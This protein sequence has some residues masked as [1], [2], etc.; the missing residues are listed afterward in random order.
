M[1][2]LKDLMAKWHRDPFY[3]SAVVLGVDIGLEGIGVWLRKGVKPLF[4]ATYL[5]SLPEA[6]PLENR[7]LKRSARR[8]RKSRKHRDFLFRQ[9]CAKCDL[10]TTPLEKKNHDPFKLRH[11]AVTSQLKSKEG[12]VICLHHLVRHRGYDYHLTEE[13]AY[14]WGD[15]LRKQDIL[16]WARTTACRPDYAKDIQYLISDWPE[17]DRDS[18]LTALEEAV[19][20]YESQPILRALRTYVAEKKP[21]LRAPIRGTQNNYPRE[22]VTAHAREIL[23]RHKS[24]FQPGPSFSQAVEELLGDKTGII[25][26]HRKEPGALADRKIKPCPFAP[27][28]FAGKKEKC[29]LNADRGLRKFKVLEFLATR[30][31]VDSGLRRVYATPELIAKLLIWVEADCEAVEA[32]HQRADLRDL[33]K[34]IEETLK[35]SSPGKKVTLAKGEELNKLYLEHLKDLLKPDLGVLG[36]RG[37]MSSASAVELLKRATVDGTS[38]EP[39]AIRNRLTD[40]Y[41][42]RLDSDRGY[43]Q[44]P[45]VEFLMG[46]PKQNDPGA[47]HGVLRRIFANPDVVKAL[48]GKEVPDYT[49][50]EVI[51]DI[52]RNANERKELQ[53]EQRARQEAKQ[54]IFSEYGLSKDANEVD[55]KRALLFDQQNG[56]CPYTGKELGSPLRADL[57]MDHMFP[58]SA[59]GISELRNLVLTHA[60]TNMAKGDRTPREAATAG[61]FGQPW[62]SILDRLPAMKWGSGKNGA[63][64]K[65]DLFKWSDA[66]S[67]PDFQNTTRVAQLARQLRDEI[68]RWMGVKGNAKLMSQRIGTPSG[69]LTG[70][71]RESWRDKLP[72]KDRGN[73]RH[74][75]WDAA[76]IS[77]IPPGKGLNHARYGGIFYHVAATVSGD[78][79]MRALE[80]LGPDLLDFEKAHFSTCLVLKPRRSRSKKAKFDET[81]YGVDQDGSLWARKPLLVPQASP[82]APKIPAK[83]V[84]EWIKDSG[85]NDEHQRLPGKVLQRWMDKGGTTPLVLRG[86]SRVGSLPVRGTKEAVPALAPHCNREGEMIGLKKTT[87]TFVRCEIWVTKKLAKDGRVL[88]DVNGQPVLEYHKRLIPHPRNLANIRN[89][90][91]SCSGKRLS[92]AGNLED[93]EMIELG[94]SEE[95][96]DLERLRQKQKGANLVAAP[97]ERA[98]EGSQTDL[99][100]KAPVSAAGSKPLAILKLSLRKIYA[101]LPRYAH[102]LQDAEGNDISKLKKGDLLLVPLNREGGICGRGTEPYKEHWYRVSALNTSGQIEM[103]LAEYKQPKV[104]SQQEVRAKALTPSEQDAWLLKVYKRSPSSADVLAHLLERTPRT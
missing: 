87:E 99:F 101:Q 59:G 8:S 39:S 80:G 42:W 60:V 41:E 5:V 46:H 33:R 23:E 92:W 27:R 94:L 31:F 2:V 66:T 91:M 35:P 68:A 28:L 75:M 43:G 20:R 21:H 90:I 81:I 47:V 25:N 103:V 84:E 36:K 3:T 51:G 76:V 13:G 88:K 96:R 40:Y 11:Q 44:F 69:F 19:A 37:S 6:A 89:R 77:H 50:I 38:F 98:V 30:Q 95:L 24:M 64:G 85:V 61:A 97:S 83:N 67:I 71:C 58:R 26:Y 48:R 10:P 104:P 15:D 22:L 17:K 79:R 29:A 82:D 78:I 49:I 57:Q 65:M 70:V 52:P 102:R 14:P 4:H 63:M 32:K 72:R 93:Q 55:R 18:V 74:H 100:P 62:E 54:K 53:S 56:I 16:D 9:W 7:R 12:L 34:M 73:L 86:G 45:Q 1:E